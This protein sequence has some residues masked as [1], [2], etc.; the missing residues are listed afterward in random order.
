MKIKHDGGGYAYLPGLRFASNGVVALPGMAIERAVLPAPRTLPQGY[1]VLRRHLDRVGRPLRALCGIELRLPSALPVQA[2]RDFNERYLAQLD[3][4]G[5]VHDDTSPLAR[6]NVAPFAHAPTEPALVAFSYTRVCETQNGSGMVI[7]GVA[8]LPTGAHYPDEVIRGGETS[9]DALLEKARYVVHDVKARIA[10]LGTTWDPS[11]SVHLYS[12]HPVT[13]EI[14]R[15]V[16][17]EAGVV[18][19]HGVTWHDAAPPVV[20]LELEVDVRRYVREGV[21]EY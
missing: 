19:T 2:F 4:W 14:G 15:D 17:A 3:A 8:E 1:E 9:H 11:A 21:A 16:L 5:L 13:F 6:T 18:P 20:D 10:A 7:S 12:T